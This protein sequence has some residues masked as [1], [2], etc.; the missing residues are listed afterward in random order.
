LEDGFSEKYRAIYEPTERNFGHIATMELT[1][2]YSF[3]NQQLSEGKGTE[4]D[5]IEE[6]KQ[7]LRENG[8]SQRA[9]N[10]IAEWYS[11]Q[12]TK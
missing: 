7:L 10:A 2:K 4:S 9:T 5:G 12:V 11:Q 3:G 1:V 6:L 8:Y